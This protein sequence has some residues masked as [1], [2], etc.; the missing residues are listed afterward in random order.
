M[1]SYVDAQYSRDTCG[2]IQSSWGQVLEL[3]QHHFCH[4][5]LAKAVTGYPRFS[6]MGG[7]LYL[8]IDRKWHTWER[9]F[10]CGHLRDKLPQ[11]LLTIIV[12]RYDDNIMVMC[13]VLFLNSP[14][15]LGVQ[16]KY[17]LVKLYNIGVFFTI[18]QNGGR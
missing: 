8:P 17:L 1:M 2:N 3:A 15:L 4:N 18:T 13:F 6:S 9:E 10:N 14:C 11:E 5:L 16:G 7:R 12:L